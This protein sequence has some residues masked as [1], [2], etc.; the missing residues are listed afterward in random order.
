MNSDYTITRN[1]QYVLLGK[2][3]HCYKRGQTLNGNGT[4]KV[5]D[6]HKKHEYISVDSYRRRKIQQ[7]PFR[8][9]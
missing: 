3:T 7:K 6:I 8:R 2:I 9:R 5:I 4:T 1:T